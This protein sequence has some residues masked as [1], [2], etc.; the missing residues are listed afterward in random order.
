VGPKAS[1]VE[2]LPTPAYD[3]FTAFQI[4]QLAY[5]HHALLSQMH[6]QHCSVTFRAHSQG[7]IKA[8]GKLLHSPHPTTHFPNES[9]TSNLT[10]SLTIMKFFLTTIIFTLCALFS[11]STAAPISAELLKRDVFD[12]PVISPGKGTVWKVD[13]EQTVTW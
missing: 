5:R 10:T 8:T 7:F 3:H 9:T 2:T 6:G 11:F 13:T 4:T 12:P 1:L